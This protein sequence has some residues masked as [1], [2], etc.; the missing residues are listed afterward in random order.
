[1]E[2]TLRYP[3][4][5]FEVDEIFADTTSDEIKAMGKVMSIFDIEP[6]PSI[7]LAMV[8]MYRSGYS[9]AEN[10]LPLWNGKT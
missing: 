9:R 2:L 5:T 8:Q 4:I 7:V 10:D 1:M 3:T 6:S